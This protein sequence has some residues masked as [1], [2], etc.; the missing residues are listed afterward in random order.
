MDANQAAA[1]IGWS[2]RQFRRRFVDTGKITPHEFLSGSG[3]LKQMFLAIDV[4]KLATVRK[5]PG[6]RLRM[7]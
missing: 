5:Q 3:H 1:T 7:P 2:S 6:K 4:A